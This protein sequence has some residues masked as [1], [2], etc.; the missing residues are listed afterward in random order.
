MGKVLELVAIAKAGRVESVLK[1]GRTTIRDGG[2]SPT[3]KA[4]RSRACGMYRGV[5]RFEAIAYD[6][7][8]R[9]AEI[10]EADLLAHIRCAPHLQRWFRN[11]RDGSAGRKSSRANAVYLAIFR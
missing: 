5:A 9:I 2:W 3:T 6:L 7:D 1:V 10:L 4:L 8:A 11:Q